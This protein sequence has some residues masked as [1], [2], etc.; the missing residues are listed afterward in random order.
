MLWII[1]FHFKDVVKCLKKPLRRWGRENGVWDDVWIY[2]ARFYERELQIVHL[3]SSPTMFSVW[4][5]QQRKCVSQ[6]QLF[7]NLGHR[8]SL[9]PN[10]AILCACCVWEERD[11]DSAKMAITKCE[12]KVWRRHVEAAK[13]L[14]AYVAAVGKWDRKVKIK[15]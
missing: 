13:V 7:D 15:W 5:M 3:I 1:I 12:G 6:N 4:C 14:G 11:W 10:S 9:R 8:T 2:K